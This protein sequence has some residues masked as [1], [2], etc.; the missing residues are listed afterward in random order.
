LKNNQ[1]PAIRAYGS[2]INFKSRCDMI[3]AHPLGFSPQ[4]KEIICILAPLRDQLLA[5]C[6]KASA[7]R[8]EIAHGRVSQVLY[9]RSRQSM[10]DVGYVLLPSLYKPSKFRIDGFA[11][12]Q[13]MSNDVMHFRQ[14][15]TKLYLRLAAL[16]E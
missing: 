16:S 10:R 9:S 6:V 2:V 3:K 13:Y 5:E 14:E 8:N 15:F 11:T 12:Y 1:P 4:E 7:H